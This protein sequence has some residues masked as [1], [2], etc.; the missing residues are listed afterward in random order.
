MKFAL[1]AVAAALN[2]EKQPLDPEAELLEL[3]AKGYYYG[4]TGGNM[5]MNWVTQGYGLNV[6]GDVKLKDL[7]QTVMRTAP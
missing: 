3:G 2:V 4:A 6:L 7:A 1:I 5:M